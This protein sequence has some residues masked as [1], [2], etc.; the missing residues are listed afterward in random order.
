MPVRNVEHVIVSKQ[1]YFQTYH[2]PG[3]TL[4]IVQ[5]VYIH[6]SVNIYCTCSYQIH[7]KNT[8]ADRNSIFFNFYYYQLISFTINRFV[9]HRHFKLFSS[10]VAKGFFFLSVQKYILPSKCVMQFCSSSEHCVTFTKL[11]TNRN[12]RILTKCKLLKS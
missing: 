11:Y 9:F 6:I 1:N 12:C 4:F 5:T 7:S 10:I 8:F 2:I 3:N